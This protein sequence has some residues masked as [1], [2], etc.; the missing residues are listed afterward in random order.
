MTNVTQAHEDFVQTRLDGVDTTSDPQYAL[1]P[2]GEAMY[3][4]DPIDVAKKPIESTWD[5]IKTIVII[6]ASSVGGVI[7]L[8]LLLFILSCT[9]LFS[10]CCGG[11]RRNMGFKG[12][13]TRRV[14]QPLNY[15]APDM[16]A[17]HYGQHGTITHGTV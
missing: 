14:Y 7:V 5:K 8:G 1:L 4:P 15:P 16:H 12:Q 17:P 10:S 3:S 13:E 11:R 9:G 2:P 6:V